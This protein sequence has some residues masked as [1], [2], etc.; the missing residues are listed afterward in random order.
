MH[1]TS[2]VD[3]DLRLRHPQWAAYLESTKKHHETARMSDDSRRPTEFDHG[4]GRGSCRKVAGG[5]VVWDD[6]TLEVVR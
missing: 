4:L 1:T 3:E 6:G 2:R 5:V